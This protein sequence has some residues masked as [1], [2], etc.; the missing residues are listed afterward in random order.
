MKARPRFIVLLILSLLICGIAYAKP[1]DKIWVFTSLS[2]PQIPERIYGFPSLEA[3]EKARSKGPY[4]FPSD[5]C[6]AYELLPVELRAEVRF[7]DLPE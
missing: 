4:T 7:E 5:T 6:V 3:C 1:P 2:Y